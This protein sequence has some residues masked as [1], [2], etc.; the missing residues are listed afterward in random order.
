[1][2][3]G[4]ESVGPSGQTGWPGSLHQEIIGILCWGWIMMLCHVIKRLGTAVSVCCRTVRCC[5]IRAKNRVAQI[6]IM[7]GVV[8]VAVFV[9]FLSFVGVA[10][11]GLELC[12]V[13][14][15]AVGPK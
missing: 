2:E 1:M 14:P 15:C 4:N 8:I 7:D 12:C 3:Q 11:V 9:P 13:G 10:S 6:R 5:G